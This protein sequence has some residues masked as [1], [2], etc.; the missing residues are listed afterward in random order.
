MLSRLNFSVNSQTP[1]ASKNKRHKP[2]FFTH[3]DTVALRWSKI[4]TDGKL[5]WPLAI[6]MTTKTF[7]K[8][9]ILCSPTFKVFQKH[10][11]FSHKTFAITMAET[12]RRRTV[13]ER[14]S[15]YDNS[16]WFRDRVF[17]NISHYEA[18]FRSAME[19][20]MLRLPAMEFFVLNVCD[21]SNLTPVRQATYL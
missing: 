12:S 2:Y 11:F 6:R 1:H 8:Q 14:S 15:H 18:R 13:L 4:L 9:N 19:F 10:T 20:F 17:C 7:M 5:H 21:E 16:K 3:V